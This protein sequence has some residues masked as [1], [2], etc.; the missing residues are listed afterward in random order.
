MFTHD[1]I[2]RSTIHDH[3]RALDVRPGGAGD[4]RRAAVAITIVGDDEGR[5]CF[6]LTR[7]AATL[8]RHAGQW[9]LPGGGIDP[10]ED[11][12]T[13]AR[14]ELL[15]EV[16]LSIDAAELLGRLD[17]YPTRSGWSITPVVFWGPATPVLATDPA[18]V[19]AV[20]LVP[21][22]AID[23]EPKL[24]P[25]VD[26]ARPVIQLGLYNRFLHAPTA[27]ILYQLREV[28]LHGRAT[29]VDHFDQPEFAWR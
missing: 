18:E 19:E 21:L 17:D 7:R 27:A 22:E 23:E 6:L 11:L 20:H 28:G 15:E 26:P 8:R 10:G 1:A 9:A 5:A 16:G 12:E 24:L 3:L 25:G 4:L 2:L 29:R 14:R 13:A